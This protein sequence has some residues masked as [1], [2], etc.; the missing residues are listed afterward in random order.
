MP[1]ATTQSSILSNARGQTELRVQMLPAVLVAFR[2]F[3]SLEH[4][5]ADLADSLGIFHDTGTHL[6]SAADAFL[7]YP[8]EQRPKMMR[9][10]HFEHSPRHPHHHHSHHH[11]HHHVSS[12]AHDKDIENNVLRAE[13][14]HETE[15]TAETNTRSG[16]S[17]P[18]WTMRTTGDAVWACAWEGGD[19][20]CKGQVR[21]GK[22]QADGSAESW[23]AWMDADNWLSCETTV[24]G[25][26]NAAETD[27]YCE[28]YGYCPTRCD[29]PSNLPSNINTSHSC[30]VEKISY[31]PGEYCQP[32]CVDGFFS[33]ADYLYCRTDRLAVDGHTWAP[34]NFTCE[35]MPCAAPTWINNSAAIACAQG[36][37]II[38][39]SDCAANCAQGYAPDRAVLTCSYG[40]FFPAD[41]ECKAQPCSAEMGMNPLNGHP[42]GPCKEGISIPSFSICTLQCESGYRPTVDTLYCEFG[43]FT[44]AEFWCHEIPCAVPATL[45]QAASPCLEGWETYSSSSI[46]SNSSCSPQ[47]EPGYDSTVPSMECHKGELTPDGYTCEPAPCSAPT[48]IGNASHPC[49]EGATISHDQPC[50][51]QCDAGFTPSVVGL[52]CNKSRLVPETFSCDPDPCVTPSVANA[53]TMSCQGLSAHS[54]LSG[55]NC[56]PV[57]DAGYT[58]TVESLSCDRGVLAPATFNCQPAS[59][60]APGT[61]ANAKAVS[62]REGSSIHSGNGCTLDCLS[63]YTP[64]HTSPLPCSF[65]NLVI[66]D[67]AS[68]VEASCTLPSDVQHMISGACLGSSDYTLPSG[69]TCTPGCQG[70]YIPSE[71]SL[72][73]HRGTLNPG[74]FECRHGHT[75]SVSSSLASNL[76]DAGISICWE[77][78]TIDHNHNCTATCG[79]G[80]G[81]T[82]SV[83]RLVCNDGVFTPASFDC[84][85]NSE[86]GTNARCMA[87]VNISHANT[88]SCSEGLVFK[89]GETCTPQCHHHHHASEASLTC[90]SG[91]WSP[92]TFHCPHHSNHHHHHRR[93]RS[94]NT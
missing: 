17:P 51:A 78:E 79:S 16:S 81:F 56:T 22:Y 42:S 33:S 44:P 63:G 14:L 1:C 11:R 32:Q 37:H 19:C 20:C 93:R 67:N 25:E 59:C 84:I 15:L 5:G 50:T 57:C 73:C 54:I 31:L 68:C 18:D 41:F 40:S 60:A 85:A 29:P 24:L 10:E 86:L 43:S 49:T 30:V 47:C 6:M 80:T 62:C 76:P 77:G 89:N 69:H 27:K 92:L 28:C 82:P 26:P 75:C 36:S 94:H 46:P 21:L 53:P 71:S 7:Q 3:L 87:P 9:R 38:H 13:H 4:A 35:G 23:T 52:V 34:E 58:P 90:D 48:G 8:D 45:H 66:P 83:E 65:G 39:G 70:G 64:T 2:L 91:T 12:F 72:S 55:H 61:I 88:Q 74:T